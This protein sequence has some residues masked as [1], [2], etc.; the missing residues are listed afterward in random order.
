[1]FE[2][3]TE[4]CS[5]ALQDYLLQCVRTS[6]EAVLAPGAY[7]LAAP[8]RIPSRLKLRGAD[9]GGGFV[10]ALRPQGCRALEFIDCH[11]AAVSNLMIW[12]TGDVSP[13]TYLYFD[14]TYS[15]V[16]RDVRVHL[17][18]MTPPCTEAAITLDAASGKNNNLIFDN[19]IVRSDGLSY[20]AGYWFKP[21]CGTAT[22]TA[23]NVETSNIGF[24]WQGG[25]ITL[26]NPYMERIGRAL[27]RADLESI[28]E[29]VHF[30]CHG[31]TMISAHSGFAFQFYRAV[32]NLTFHGTFIDTKL[33]Q[34]TGYWYTPDRGV[35]VRF[36]GCAM[37]VEKWN[38]QPVC[39]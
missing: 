3:R 6:Q 2:H 23:P 25:R 37:D 8:L 27:V 33:S 7:L 14:R 4:E 38:A 15:H 30:S 28:D 26:S 22:L 36:Y 1:M 35:N 16:V 21:G 10:C 20:P 32:R 12:A 11:H 13:D 34:W 17:S 39:V 9:P 19:V 18:A 31:G 5:Q 29:P 24:Y